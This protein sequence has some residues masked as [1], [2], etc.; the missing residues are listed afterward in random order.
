MIKD[1]ALKGDEARGIAP[2]ATNAMLQYQ[3]ITREEQAEDQPLY[4]G[5]NARRLI[6]Q[7]ERRR[8]GRR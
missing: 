4:Y 7:M 3:R 2:D 5:G 8:R 6:R 1:F